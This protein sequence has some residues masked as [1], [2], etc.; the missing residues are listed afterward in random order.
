M[1]GDDRSDLA[2]LDHEI[3]SEMRLIK[4]SLLFL[5]LCGA[6][7]VLCIL[8]HPRGL[9]GLLDNYIVSRDDVFAGR[10]RLKEDELNAPFNPTAMRIMFMG[11]GLCGVVLAVS[12]AGDYLHRV[13]P[14]RRMKTL[15]GGCTP[16]VHRLLEHAHASVR[17]FL[18]APSE[19]EWK[20]NVFKR[21]L[22]LYQ[23]YEKLSI[24]ELQKKLETSQ[25]WDTGVSWFSR[26]RTLDDAIIL[27][28]YTQKRKVL[29]VKIEALEREIQLLQGHLL[30]A[31][32]IRIR[33]V[34]EQQREA[35][36]DELQSILSQYPPNKDWSVPPSMRTDKE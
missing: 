36:E 8:L 23:L 19:K 9:T 17:S 1:S 18:V 5:C 16:E 10:R 2:Q 33:R 30:S 27:A 21:M 26:G 32:E 12:L 22:E 11:A 7:V 24:E 6:I 3:Q 20:P 29:D 13:H 4:R 31:P 25:V 35:L 14:K 15:A 34:L 28:I